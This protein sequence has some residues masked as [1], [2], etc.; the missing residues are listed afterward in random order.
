MY[1]LSPARTFNP[2]QLLTITANARRIYTPES[3]ANFTRDILS[4]I[5]VPGC[6]AI[7]ESVHG[8]GTDMLFCVYLPVDSFQTATIV[9]SRPAR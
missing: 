5:R 7:D 4:L 9:D 1:A 6:M 3:A 2:F 8:F